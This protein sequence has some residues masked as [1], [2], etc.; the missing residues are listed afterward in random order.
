MP[1][2]NQTVSTASNAQAQQDGVMV[3]EGIEN[4]ELPKTIVTRIAKSPLANN[5]KFNKDT[6]TAATRGATVFINYLT[7]VLKAV[8]LIEM[9]DMVPILQREL[10]VFRREQ[11]SATAK[12]KGRASQGS[13]VNTAN[14][15]ADGLPSVTDSMP[16]GYHPTPPGGVVEFPKANDTEGQE[17]INGTGSGGPSDGVETHDQD[18]VNVDSG[19][20]EQDEQ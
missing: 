5:A 19:P 8:E 11:K 2:P 13:A 4:Y 18:G 1:R 9:P 16:E 20:M 14:G 10:E 15:H 17:E 6:I 12:G 3:S 7:D